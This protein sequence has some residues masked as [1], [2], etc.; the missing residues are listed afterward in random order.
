MQRI[1]V[2]ICLLLLTGLPVSAAG[3]GVVRGNVELALPDGRRVPGEWIRLLL[4]TEAVDA[5]AIVAAAEALTYEPGVR[6]NRIHMDFFKA[7]SRR[8]Q[9]DARYVAATSVSAEDGTF[10]FPPVAP[11]RY[12]VLVAFPALIEGCK[13]AWQVPVMVAADKAEA[14]RLHNDNLL[15]PLPPPRPVSPRF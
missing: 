9:T 11:G 7:V 6:L 8:I 10:A 13:V 3:V 5:K 1:G 2:V 14:V 4:V 12:W 15:F